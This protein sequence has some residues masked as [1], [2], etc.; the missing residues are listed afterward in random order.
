[1]SVEEAAA[2][3]DE[4]RQ[5]LPP[6]GTGLPSFEVWRERIRKRFE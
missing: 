3:T 4:A 6:E 5:G 2:V 1:M